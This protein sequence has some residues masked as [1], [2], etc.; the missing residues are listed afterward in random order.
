MLVACSQNVLPSQLVKNYNPNLL[1]KHNHCSWRN[2]LYNFQSK[3]HHD[4]K[5]SDRFREGLRQFYSVVLL[6]AVYS[7]SLCNS[8]FWVEQQ[9]HIFYHYEN[10]TRLFGIHKNIPH[11]LIYLIC[12]RSE[13]RMIVKIENVD[14]S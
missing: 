6:F 12:R 14:C 1:R 13:V 10:Q 11:V 2:R 9:I 3:P 7:R 4:S 8:Y 5:A